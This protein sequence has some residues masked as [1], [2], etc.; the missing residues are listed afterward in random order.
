MKFSASRPVVIGSLVFLALLALAAM[1]R[2]IEHAPNFAP[3]IGVALFAGFF[4]RRWWVGL[5]APMTAMAATDAVIGFY[6][7]RM[8]AVVYAA[9]ALAVAA[10]V[11]LRKRFTALRLASCTLAASIGFFVLTNMGVWLFSGMYPQTLEGLGA[12]FAAAVPFF[13]YGFAGDV[14]Y[15]T[16]LFGSWALIRMLAARRAAVLAPAA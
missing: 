9:I 12:C 5:L 13:K 15:T 14:V 10:R 11:V 4:F 1:G 16:G 2:F 6:D 7:W 3:M 8:M